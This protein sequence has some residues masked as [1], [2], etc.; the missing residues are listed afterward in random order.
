MLIVLY[1]TAFVIIYIYNAYLMS[2][3]VFCETLAWL[4]CLAS[5]M[6]PEARDCV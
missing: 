1:C 3:Q 5:S 2:L 6:L 4:H